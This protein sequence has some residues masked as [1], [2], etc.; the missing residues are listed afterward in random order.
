MVDILIP[1]FNANGTKI[2][3]DGTVSQRIMVVPSSNSTTQENVHRETWS[4]RRALDHNLCCAE[5][6]RLPT[7]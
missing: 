3:D 1:Y 6:A 4:S 5:N 7:E 2:N